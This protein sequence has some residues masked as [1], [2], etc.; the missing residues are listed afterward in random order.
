MHE[1]DF[2]RLESKV[3]VLTKIM[4]E[5]N[6]KLQQV[7]IIAKEPIASRP[8]ANKKQAIH[9]AVQRRMLMIDHGYRLKKQ[10]NL[11]QPPHA[12]RIVAYLKTQDPKVFDGL[13]RN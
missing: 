10:F 1:E 4:E 7:T 12:N 9:E 2:E 8:A 6:N 5:I 11:A 3:D 13:K